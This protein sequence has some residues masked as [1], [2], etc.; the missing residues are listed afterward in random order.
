MSWSVLRCA[1]AMGGGG[2]YCKDSAALGSR[3]QVEAKSA[4]PD[5]EHASEAGAERPTEHVW[6]CFKHCGRIGARRQRAILFMVKAEGVSAAGELAAGGYAASSPRGG[7]LRPARSAS[8]STSS[9]SRRRSLAISGARRARSRRQSAASRRETDRFFGMVLN[10]HEAP[11][12]S[13]VLSWISRR[14]ASFCRCRL[15]LELCRQIQQ[16]SG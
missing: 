10:E 15:F 4:D 7:P 5:G 14:R 16:S 11:E 8:C 13:F 9:A 1:S 3:Y 12:F 2:P 6:G